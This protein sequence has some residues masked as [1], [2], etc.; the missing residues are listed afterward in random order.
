MFFWVKI[1]HLTTQKKGD[2]SN[3]IFFEEK[4][5]QSCFIPRGEKNG[6]I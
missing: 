3:K 2:K 5:A 4:M 1:C 6:H